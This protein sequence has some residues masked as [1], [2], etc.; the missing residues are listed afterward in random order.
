[1]GPELLYSRSG[2]DEGTVLFDQTPDRTGWFGRVAMR[3]SMELDTRQK[4]HTSLF[5]LAA[6]TSTGDS[7][8]LPPGRGLRVVGS[9]F[10]APAA[11][12]VYETYGGLDGLV[13][14]Y[15]GN[16]SVQAST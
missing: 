6:G 2:D 5:D 13:A 15:V 4:T 8:D 9:T 10:V 7:P 11:M 14:A 16:T 1:M 12:D 3:A